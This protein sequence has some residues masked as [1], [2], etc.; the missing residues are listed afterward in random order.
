MKSLK[1]REFIKTTTMAS[2]ALSAIPFTGC[3]LSDKEK[4]ISLNQTLL[5][6]GFDNEQE[7]N[8]CIVTDGSGLMWM[9]SLRRISYPENAEFVSSFH[10]DG[11]NWAET[12][13]VT[14]SSGQYETPVAACATNG[15]PVVAWT[16]IE[17]D[18]WNINVAIGQ[19]KGFKNPYTL[20][21]KSGKSIN[22]VLIAPSKNRNW[23]AW[24]NLHKGKFTIY[25]SK[26]ENSQWSQP[27]IIDKGKNSCFDPSIAE[28]KNG[29]LYV[30]YG[31][32]DGFHQNIEMSII[33]GEN[34]KVKEFIPIAV[35]G[36]LIDR[37]NINSR[38]ALNFD[39]QDNL[40]ISYENNRNNSRMEDGDN[41]TGDRCCAILSYQNGK[42]VEVNKLGKWLFD[43]KNDHKPTFIKDLQGN[44]YLATHCGGNFDDPYWTYRISWLDPENGWQKPVTLLETKV[45]GMLIAPAIA[46][47]ENGKFWFSTCLEKTFKSEVTDNEKTATRK[48]L[49]EL[50]V[51]EFSAPELSEK[52]RSIDFKETQIKEYLPDEKTISTFSGHPKME[53]CKMDIK[54]ETYTL[55]YGNLH[56][57]SNSSHC[58][59]AGT[60]GTLHDDYRFGMFSEGYDFIG[61]TDH[62]SSTTELYWRKSI[63]FADFY[64]ESEKFVAIPSIE[65]TLQSDPNLDDIQ[66]GAGHYNI[67]FASS[68]DAR[69]YIRNKYEIYCPH[70]PESNISPALW[71]MLEKKDINCITIPHHSADKVHL[72]DWNVNN[73]KYVPM[74]E[75]FQCR[76]NNEY[77][78]CPREKNIS[79]H[80][81]T[82]HKHAFIDYAL[83]TKK[84]KMGFIASGDH[85]NM[86][87]GVAALWVKEVSR[88]GILEALRSRCTFATTGDKMVV[89][90]KVNGAISGSTCYTDEVPKME[91]EVKGQYPLEKIEI[92]RNSKVIQEF[93][94]DKETLAFEQVFS[95]H[96]Y[97]DEDD[98]LYYY[99][100]VTQKNKAL[101]WS[102]PIWVERA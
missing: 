33:D 8:P 44:L 59:P 89:S 12:D 82:H 95:D 96:N 14:K 43:G 6:K 90:L 37:V 61:I 10:F 64:N 40:W 28:A 58:W 88:E 3:S 49:T 65:W 57:H 81:S 101:A 7:E 15:K 87:V 50:K 34:L 4:E 18:N 22:P 55:L 52:Y 77:P 1:R 48:R 67:I 26:S 83:K 84:Y 76:G 27:I 94:T 97:L 73:P 63:R 69:K 38:P 25:I 5:L 68:E 86:G 17:G 53:R 85:N 29:D 79:R 71:E 60:D 75:I 35:G 99:I 72:M 91:I 24:E 80:V 100:R 56:E 19:T 45:K 51:F 20:P 92:L 39:A 66:H 9:Y 46:F 36:G 31:L 23:I 2:I 47:D 62:A 70:T 13:P 98:I 21:V 32:T 11:K 78:G 42:I 74:V 30:A 102:S 41:Y 93:K 54:G 16:E